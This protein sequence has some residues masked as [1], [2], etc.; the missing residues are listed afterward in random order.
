MALRTWF[1]VGFPSLLAIAACHDDGAPGSTQPDG[2]VSVV[3]IP[4]DAVLP[5][6]AITVT[7]AYAAPAGF[8]LRPTRFDGHL[9]L[10]V[11]PDGAVTGALSIGS[12]ER[13]FLAAVSGQVDGDSIVLAAGNVD[14]APSERLQ[15]DELRLS[16]R[17]QD[18]DHA[19]D[20]AAGDARGSFT[21]TSSE[22]VETSPYAASI[23]A[24]SDALAT[25]IEIAE[26]SPRLP[27]GAVTI[28]FAEP[29]RAAQVTAALRVLAGG[30]PVAGS[31]DAT[32]VDGLIT[33]TRFQPADFLPFDQAISLDVGGLTD[34]SGNAL[35]AAASALRVVGDPSAATGNLG[36]ENGLRGWVVVGHA[37]SVGSFGGIA[38]AAG[39]SQAVI[40][41]VG[42]L[43][44]YLDVPADAD[45]LHVSLARLSQLSEV[46]PDYTATIALHRASGE[47]I[48]SFD[49]RAATEQVVPCTACGPTYGFQLGPLTR[50]LDLTAVRGER[51]WLTIDARSFFFIGMPALAIVLDDLRLVTSK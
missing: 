30:Q 38:P 6:L 51:I 39:T 9:Y 14:A 47:T 29:V 36:F 49:A 43:A 10:R 46:A 4:R 25:S 42:T 32:P 45:A 11:D 5:P 12:S 13:A 26:R 33:S 15:W 37:D 41:A 27:F 7:P 20:G 50:D 28:H 24:T 44:G 23:A 2:S 34:P 22:F 31:F 40:D 35:T 16:L 21:A 18:G 8:L 17:D 19:I 48:T 3:T 1:L